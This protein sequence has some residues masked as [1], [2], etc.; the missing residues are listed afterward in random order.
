MGSWRS[1]L[2]VFTKGKDSRQTFEP[3][4]G[5][6]V[7]PAIKQQ[8]SQ[9]EMAKT[10]L[11]TGGAGFIASHCATEL[12]SDGYSVGALDNLEPQN[13]GTMTEP[14]NKLNRRDKLLV[15]HYSSLVR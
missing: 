1:S 9:P 3:F 13:Y 7:E 14:P 8:L 5:H 2:Q 11:I 4:R 15:S 12:L 10:V 6:G